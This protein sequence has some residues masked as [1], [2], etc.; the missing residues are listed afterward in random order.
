M[1]F[2]L[3]FTVW[4]KWQEGLLYLLN[5]LEENSNY[6][7]KVFSNMKFDSFKEYFAYYIRQIV[8]KVVNDYFRI[9]VIS[10]NNQ[11]IIEATADF[12]AYGLSEMLYRWVLGGCELNSEIYHKTIIQVIGYRIQP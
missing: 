12:Y 5:Y 7:K 2:I 3:Q 8:K 4:E 9:H 11:A 10:N 6:Y 1:H